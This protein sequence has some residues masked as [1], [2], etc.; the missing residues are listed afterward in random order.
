[1]TSF[2]NVHFVHQALILEIWTKNT[3]LVTFLP[4][5]ILLGA[6]EFA[7]LGYF[8]AEISDGRRRV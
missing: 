5:A 8:L 7:I 4:E 1:M 2:R 3:V 6:A